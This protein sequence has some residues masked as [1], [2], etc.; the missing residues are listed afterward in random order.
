[1]SSKS[2][3]IVC[4][5]VISRLVSEDRYFLSNLKLQKLLYYVQAWSIAIKKTK[6]FEGEFQAWIHGPVNREIYDRF[7]ESKS[8]YSRIGIEDI[9]DKNCEEKLESEEKELI[10]D[11]LEVYATFTDVE[12]E[13]M[14]H[15]EEPWIKAREGYRPME[16]CEVNIDLNL[17]ESYYSKRISG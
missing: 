9:I 2:V 8:L 1:M 6:A 13:K 10:N 12:L 15:S 7:K 11:V 14:T 4:D 5:Y 16:R 17:V 3:N